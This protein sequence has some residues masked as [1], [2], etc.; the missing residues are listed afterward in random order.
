MHHEERERR[1]IRSRVEGEKAEVESRGKKVTE[2]SRYENG[3]ADI[4]EE[5]NSGMKNVEGR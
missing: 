4:R 1:V 5:S 3:S 2:G